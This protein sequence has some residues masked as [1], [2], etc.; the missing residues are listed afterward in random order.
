M[1]IIG[2]LEIW[3]RDLGK[4]TWDEANTEVAKLGSGWRLPTIEEFKEILYPNRNRI[5]NL[6]D[7]SYW[8]ST[9]DNSFT[10]WYFY[11][12]DGYASYY[13]KYNSPYVRAV[14]DLTAEVVAEYL[15]KE[16]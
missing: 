2:E 16:F 10:A 4:M 6:Q 9:E 14:R 15:L 1:L 7:E 3:P 5:L 11:F 13:Y 12:T 8:S